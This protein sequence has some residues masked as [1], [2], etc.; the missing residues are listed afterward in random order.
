[1]FLIEALVNR[2]IFAALK[3]QGM[4]LLTVVAYVIIEREEVSRTLALLP[5]LFFM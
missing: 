3:V 5:L 4:L 1:M 2:S